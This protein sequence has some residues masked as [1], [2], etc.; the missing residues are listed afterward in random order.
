[1]YMIDSY[2]KQDYKKMGF[3]LGEV[4]DAHLVP[5]ANDNGQINAEILEDSQ[6]RMNGN[7]KNMFLY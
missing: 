7:K 3:L 5:D 6:S 2:V 1:M 4:F